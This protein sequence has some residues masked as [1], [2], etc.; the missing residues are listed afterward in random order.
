MK[1]RMILDT[2]MLVTFLLLLDYGLVHNRGHEILGILFLLLAFSI[3]NGTF[4]GTGLSNG[5][6]GQSREYF[7]F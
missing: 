2:A 3:R 4:P 7:L 5:A 1:K 6:A